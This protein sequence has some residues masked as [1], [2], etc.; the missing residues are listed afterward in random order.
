[1]HDCR[2]TWHVPIWKGQLAGLA[3][4]FTRAARASLVDAA[5]TAAGLR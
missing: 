2:E 1:M 3:M 4:V 5:V